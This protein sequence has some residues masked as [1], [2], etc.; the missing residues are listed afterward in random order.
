MLFL[1]LVE[2]I[3]GALDVFS[4]GYLTAAASY[5]SS[6]LSENAAGQKSLVKAH[7]NYW[8]AW[9]KMSWIYEGMNQTYESSENFR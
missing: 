1:L 7:L 8:L 6:N 3:D 5:N 2:L 4:L 9:K